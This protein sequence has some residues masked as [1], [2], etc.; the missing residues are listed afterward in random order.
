MKKITILLLAVALLLSMAACTAKQP[1]PAT[2]TQPE[3]TAVHTTAPE[4]TQESTQA[5]ESAVFR[6][7]SLKGPTSMGLVKLMDDN[8]NGNSLNTYESNMVTG[9]DEVTAALVNGDADIAMLPANAAAT[10]YQKAGGF[11]VV[12]INT[13]GVLYVVENGEEIQSVEDLAGKT[14]YLTGKGTTPEYGL[15]YLLAAHGI[16]E[17][18]TLEFK[19]EAAEVVAAMTED[20]AAIGLLPQP[21]V[22]SA[23]MQN[24]GLRIALDLTKEW[25]AVSSD[26]SMVTGV[27]VVRNEV[28]EAN[29][30]QIQAFLQEYAASVDY[31]NQNPAQAAQWIEELGIVGK[32]AIA[33][34]ALPNCNL[35]CIT[36]EE[37]KTALSGYLQAL[38]DQNPN[39]IG[40]AM[41]DDEFYRSIG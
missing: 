15:R 6:V 34:K 31:V 14:I 41:P 28:L 10:L 13:L 5:Y 30:D 9:A 22:T 26:S 23:L 25:A 12:A 32:A 20:V 2:D 11:S 16:E 40:G 39:A 1:T 33:E 7:Y 21:F 35:V 29:P 27:T 19:A 8:A 37:M 36:G 18:V 3:T 38:F 17:Q 4:T 24:E